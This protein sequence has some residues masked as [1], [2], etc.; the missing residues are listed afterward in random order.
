[1]TGRILHVNVSPG[2]IP[3]RAIAEGTLEIRGFQGDSWAHPQLHGGPSQT[4]LIIASEAIQELALHGYPVF[5]GALGE[6]LT[7]AGLDRRMWRAGQQ[8]RVGSATVELTKVRSPCNTLDVY[9]SADRV[10]IQNA[11]YDLSVKRGDFRSEKWALSG[12]YARV[13][14]EGIVRPGDVMT[15]ESDL[16]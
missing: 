5:P 6:N 10:P 16:A 11:I 4:V 7:T 15:L 13:V 1:V 9:G 2:G 14:R 3:K 8:Y 12:F